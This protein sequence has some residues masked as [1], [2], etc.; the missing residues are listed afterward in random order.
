MEAAFNYL[1][2]P[3]NTQS[4][5]DFEKAYAMVQKVRKD[6]SIFSSSGYIND[7][8]GGSI[9]MS[10][11]W[12]G[13]MGIAAARAK[14]AKNKQ[15]IEVFPPTHGAVIFIDTMAIP[16]DAK[17]LDNA[18][19]WMNYVLE[20]KVAAADTNTVTYAN[21]VPASLPYVDAKIKDNDFVFLKPDMVAKL[22][23]PKVY[24]P[25]QRRLVTRL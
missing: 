23:P 12:S 16:A 2:I 6:V 18:Y 20:P 22:I 10:L 24:T 17:N 11:G 8:A 13:D 3:Q 19:K 5:A 21:P 1:G 9:C 4:P 14:A 15:D 25:E 7:L